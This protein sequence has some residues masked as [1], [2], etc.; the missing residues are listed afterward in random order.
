MAYEQLPSI[1]N[2]TLGS[3]YN[4]NE[5]FA[6]QRQGQQQAQSIA[7][8]TPSQVF[9]LALMSL[10][11]QQQQLGTRPFQEQRF[12]A[13]EAQS[14]AV[15]ETPSSLI[16]ASPQLQASVRQAGVSAYQ[17]VV[18]GAEQG[19][20]TFGEQ[21]KGLG[22][23]IEQAR[24][25]GEDIRKQE[26]TNQKTAQTIVEAAIK[27]GSTGLKELLRTSPDIFK[28]AGYGTKEFS[29]VATGLAAKETEERR[30]FD[31][32][33]G[34]KGG[35]KLLSPS[36]AALL[37]VPYGTSEAEASTL[38]ITPLTTGQLGVEAQKL[39]ENAQSGLRALDT[40]QSELSQGKTSTLFKAALPGRLFARTFETA[41]KETAD[42]ITRLRTG[43]AINANE[44]KFYMSQLPNVKDLTDPGTIEYKINLLRTLFN[45][46]AT[47]QKAS[48]QKSGKQDI[49][50]LRQKY[51][52]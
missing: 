22:S 52:Y 36:E 49:N 20:Q 8:S 33:E 37:G 25:F 19:M 15:R 39:R 7:A 44:E 23:A 46:M 2:R 21:I 34:G 31:I 10:L 17:P 50:S 11:K 16:G 41:K 48:T 29:A 5:P 1:Q 47:V 13:Q 26:E 35:G 30:Q 40:L 45:S 43:A 28:R 27:S 51:N 18:S 12:N 32:K 4:S 9:N 3:L 38:G 42:V 14:R 6:I 24:A